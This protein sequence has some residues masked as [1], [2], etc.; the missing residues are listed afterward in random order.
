MISNV[1]AI[2]DKMC[3]DGFKDIE[4]KCR[5]DTGYIF[6]RDDKGNTMLHYAAGDGNLNAIEKLM[7]HGSCPFICNSFGMTPLSNIAGCD[8]SLALKYMLE[9][10]YPG[11]LDDNRAELMAIAASKGKFENLNL[12]ISNGFNC[13]AYYRGDPILYWAMQSASLDIIRLLHKHG[14]DINAING[15]GKTPIFD[16]SGFGL[17]DILEYLISHG[18]CIDKATSDGTTP[19][20]I[21]SCYNQIDVT[22]ILLSHNCDIDAKTT[23]GI[24]ALL[25]AVVYGNVE[26]VRLLIDNGADKNI[27]DRKNKGIDAYCNRI[28]SKRIKNQM[29]TVLKI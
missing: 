29:K 3:I 13:D 10:S 11:L 23:G 24:T 22:R 27:A 14:A 18:A 16:A 28:K 20:I 1:E 9:R 5:K 25:Y 12:M 21:A 8:N 6:G 15:E 26:I 7:N 2:Y 17:A 4:E 19:L